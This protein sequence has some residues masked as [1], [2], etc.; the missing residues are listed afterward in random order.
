MKLV[1]TKDKKGN[2]TFKLTGDVKD[3]AEVLYN[4]MLSD[5]EVAVSVLHAAF[6]YTNNKPALHID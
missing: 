6:Q 3:L 2:V 1:I 4:V 5:K